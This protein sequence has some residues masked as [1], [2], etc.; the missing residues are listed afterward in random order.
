MVTWKFADGPSI[1]AFPEEKFCFKEAIR[2]SL[3]EA[4]RTHGDV[5]LLGPPSP[6]SLRAGD[7]VQSGC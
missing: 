1:F 2:V 5:I 3:K 6:A 4:T 7:E